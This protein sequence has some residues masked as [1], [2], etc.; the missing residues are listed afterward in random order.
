VVDMRAAFLGRFQPMHLGHYKTIER[1]SEEYDLVIVIGS[2]DKSG[3]EEN[4]LSFEQRKNIIR[5][6]FPD[7][8]IL[9]LEDFESDEE[10]K[11]G[12]EQK[13]DADKILTRNENVEEIL[14]DSSF[15]IVKHDSFDIE[16]YSGTEVRRRIRS[17]AEWR[18][19]IPP[20]S[21]EV[22]ESLIEDIKDSG[23]QYEFEPGWKREN[24]MYGKAEK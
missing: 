5:S 13:L 18:Y 11:K 10:W 1:Y 4:P 17:D 7:I 23:V 9:G 8:E 21:K 15:E 6:C 12:L 2:A 19:L 16:I 3:T 24:S 22:L 14:E 20:C